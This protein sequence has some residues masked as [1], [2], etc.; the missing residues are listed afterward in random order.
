MIEREC[1]I[2]VPAREPVAARLAAR[3][4]VFRGG[5]RE[6]NRLFDTAGG[7][8][9]ARGVLL[10]LRTVAGRPGGV[11]TVKGPPVAG[12]AF[13][14]RDEWET[15]VDDPAALALGLAALGYRPAR[16][17]QKDRDEWDYAGTHVALD[18]LPE[19]GA[20]VEVEGE[21]AAIRGVLADLGLD[22]AAHRPENYLT[23]WDRDRAARGRPPGDPLFA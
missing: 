23:L 4:A 10:R 22:P 20:F 9:A 19:L 11:L 7:E 12:G 13:K 16:R 2:P 1:K 21:E 5:G 18:V 3:G 17:Y 14:A 8:L 15:R 6:D